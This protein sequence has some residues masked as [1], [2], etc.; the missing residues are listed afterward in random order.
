ML[1]QRVVPMIAVG[2]FLF[3]LAHN[4][5]G[6]TIV[7]STCLSRGHL[8]AQPLTPGVLARREV[9]SP[10]FAT[11]HHH[12][13]VTTKRPLFHRIG[14]VHPHRHGVVVVRRPH[15][16]HFKAFPGS[17]FHFRSRIGAVER[18]I[19]TVWITNS[20][21]SRT[22]VELVKRGPGF[23]GPRGEWYKHM[24]TRTQLRIAYGF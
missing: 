16:R 6:K 13:R 24:P 18:V 20:N 12:G 9:R 4:A 11:K 19:V 21:G 14:P 23:I 10:V 8:I 1:R 15:V 2:M 5:S 3:L 22:A 7:V 17:K